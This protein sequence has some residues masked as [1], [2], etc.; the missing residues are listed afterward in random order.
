M[1]SFLVAMAAVCL[2]ASGSDKVETIIQQG[3][4]IVDF[5][6]TADGKHLVSVDMDGTSL[7]LWDLE[8]RRMVRILT[9]A[10][11]R[12]VRCHPVNPR[13]VY[14]SSPS[15]AVPDDR[16]Y[17]GLNIFTGE[18]IGFI[19]GKDLPE[20][21][22]YHDDYI[23]KLKDGKIGIRSRKSRRYLGEL[24]GF[25]NLYRYGGMAINGHDSLVGIAG[26]FPLIWDM[27][28]ARIAGKIPYRDFLKLDTSLVFPKHPGPP[29]PKSD[30]FHIEKNDFH[31][32]YQDHF[33]CFFEK[34]DLWLCG[35]NGFLTK[36]NT[37]GTLL[38]VVASKGAPVY[39]VS[40]NG[41]HMVAATYQGVQMA[42]IP[43]KVLSPV[44]EYSTSDYKVTYH[45]SRPFRGDFFATA[46][47]SGRLRM[48]R[49]GVREKGK[50][51]MNA[52][53]SSVYGF[54]NTLHH[55]SVSPDDN[56]L[57]VS[58]Q[59]GELWE[60]P[61][62]DPEKR[63]RYDTDSLHFGVIWASGFLDEKR[64]A[65]VSQG[66]E[67]SFWTSGNKRPRKILKTHRGA[68]QGLGLT[69]DRHYLLTSD[70][71]A[72]LTVWDAVTE[73]PV[74]S[75][76]AFNQGE[77][78]MFITPDNY[79][80]ASKGALK[81]VHFARGL[82]IYPLEQFD[83][84][85]NRP[86]IV[87]SRMGRPAEVTEPYR[88]AWL[89]R[90]RKMGYTE[91]M[92]SGEL[93]APEVT[94]VNQREIESV[95]EERHVTL[96]IAVED[97][98]YPLNKFFVNL[99]G[100]PL[101][102]KN[103][104]DISRQKSRKYI[105]K[106]VV[107]LCEGNNTI[108]IFAINSKGAE[109]YRKTL[110]MACE[111]P[112]KA[113]RRLFVAAVGV[114]KYADRRFDLEYAAK[115]AADIAEMFGVMLPSSGK[116]EKGKTLLLTDEQF[117]PASLPK[118]K[119]F[120]ASAGR[121]DAVV[122]FYAGHGLLDSDLNYYLSHHDMD[123]DN[124]G[125]NGISYDDFE[126]VLEGVKAVNRLCLIDACH[127]GEIDK[128]D[129]LAET[130]TNTSGTVRF[131]SA[132]AGMRKLKG[133]G[134]AQTKALF[135]ELFMDIRW[136]IGATVVSS[137]GGMEAAMEGDQWNNGLFTWTLKKGISDGTADADHDSLISV[138]ELGEYLCREVAKL[139]AGRQTPTMRAQNNRN[140]FYI[141]GK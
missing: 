22:S 40:S 44:S 131:R 86:D 116:T 3:H 51:L 76:Y 35:Y 89:K 108:E 18:H 15:T 97:T 122:L 91:D 125:A 98:K 34:N 2:S 29:M 135:E 12:K 105:T 65:T 14:I 59:M 119:D 90:L 123:F 30:R 17:F 48:G 13:I 21:H 107:E 69:S 24:D 33:G 140:N 79:Y 63:I 111:P 16:K 57:V 73:C 10:N 5:D 94:I 141:C 50:V 138:A 93:H 56:R 4:Y 43:V 6:I 99:N 54:T 124:P 104:L 27:K 39:E 62:D 102:G 61:I 95:T 46:D 1:G 36:W 38:D 118:I 8:K 11:E 80:K 126:N 88:R 26:Q 28:N 133:H 127:S 32:G 85:F 114:S 20:R 101:K 96:D 100:V 71:Q 132:G 77:D 137:A 49:F 60:V 115:D 64:F 121:D 81:G 52:S 110:E 74:V 75:A 109:S 66:G 129:Y 37:R 67:V 41:R 139:S 7:A 55:V 112:Q 53:T 45:V 87:L 58:G 130:V 113:P 92:L 47:D 42:E 103:G 68:A 25:R 134:V 78:Y 83:L 23:L 136:G 19:P 72:N 128:E 106:T 70:H 84:R 117:T 120:F 9:Y 31:Y 82:D